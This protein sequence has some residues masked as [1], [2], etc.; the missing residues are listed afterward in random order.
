MNQERY[1]N[2]HSQYI[3]S[4]EDRMRDVVM[5]SEIDTQWAIARRKL[6]HENGDVS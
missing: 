5:N 1:N 4:D 6:H 2:R 3:V